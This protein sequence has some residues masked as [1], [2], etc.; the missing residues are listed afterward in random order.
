MND[1]NL[2]EL[3]KNMMITELIGLGEAQRK[4]YDRLQNQ[5]E[6]KD[7]KLIGAYEHHEKELNLL[8]QYQN[9]MSSSKPK[10][11]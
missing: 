8:I 11:L 10:G 5:Q 2:G 9:M 1:D 7:E 6:F 3:E 4:I